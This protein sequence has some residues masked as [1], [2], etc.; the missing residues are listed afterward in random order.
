MGLTLGA[1]HLT[2]IPGLPGGEAGLGGGKNGRKK[3]DK[4]LVLAVTDDGWWWPD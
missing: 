3:S 1:M 2:K 4:K